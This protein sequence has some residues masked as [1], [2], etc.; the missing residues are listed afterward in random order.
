MTSSWATLSGIW[1]MVFIMSCTVSLELVWC[2]R[3]SIVKISKCSTDHLVSR[4][5]SL[6]YTD[7]PGQTVPRTEGGVRDLHVVDLLRHGPGHHGPLG[8]L[9]RRSVTEGKTESSTHQAVE[10]LADLLHLTLVVADLL[11]YCLHD[12]LHL[13]LVVGDLLGH[14][15][16]GLVQPRQ[17]LPHLRS[18][19]LFLLLTHH[20]SKGFLHLLQL[21]GKVNIQIK[22]NGNYFLW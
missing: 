2:W 14:C 7:L 11:G 13:T 3:V 10:L 12:L 9:V 15:L 16:H 5:Y 20:Q 22:L 4:L 18:P 21:Q 6:G 17:L 19:L 1:V 8:L